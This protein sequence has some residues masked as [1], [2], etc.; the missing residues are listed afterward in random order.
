MQAGNPLQHLAAAKVQAA[1]QPNLG[2]AHAGA[3]RPA[4]TVGTSRPVGQHMPGFPFNQPQTSSQNYS[5][6]QVH[7]VRVMQDLHAYQEAGLSRNVQ[8]PAMQ[9]SVANALT[10]PTTHPMSPPGSVDV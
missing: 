10:H 9:V 4:A 8:L 3:S 6:S 2:A 7:A 5:Q 1:S